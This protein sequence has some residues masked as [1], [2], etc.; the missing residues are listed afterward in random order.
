MLIVFFLLLFLDAYVGV[1]DEYNGR[2]EATVHTIVWGIFII[3][4]L[5][6]IVFGG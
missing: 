6:N 3:Y 2:V 5:L 1:I 4:V